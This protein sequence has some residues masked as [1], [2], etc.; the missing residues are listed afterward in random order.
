M[1]GK[2]DNWSNR[3]VGRPLQDAKSLCRRKGE[4]SVETN[5]HLLLDCEKTQDLRESL[6]EEMTK[7]PKCNLTMTARRR[8][9][10]YAFFQRSR[11]NASWATR[12][13]QIQ[14]GF[15]IKNVRDVIIFE[16]ESPD[17]INVCTNTRNERNGHSTVP[18]RSLIKECF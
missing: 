17:S 7:G 4:I 12:K 3:S 10:S 13:K 5:A 15:S 1:S 11:P 16:Q 14:H 9:S 2:V 6:D 18:S 8:K